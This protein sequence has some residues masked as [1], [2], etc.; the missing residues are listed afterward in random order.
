MTRALGILG[1]FSALSALSAVKPPTPKTEWRSYGGDPGGMRYSPLK[2]INRGNVAKL[3]RAW[4]Y[5]HGELVTKPGERL[6]AFQSTPIVVDGIL[7]FSTPS[8]RIIAL[9][10]DSGRE[11]WTFDP[12]AGT[13]KRTYSAHRGVAY[14]SSA[15]RRDRRILFG[16]FDA[17]LI[18]LDAITGKPCI[19]FGQN[20]V[21]NLKE[22]MTDH[23][24]KSDY[25]TSSPPAIY[26]DIA[27]IGS[28]V[29]EGPGL[30][31]SGDVRA[32]DVRTGAE[33]WRFHTIP[34]P[35]EPGHETWEGDSWKDR[36]GV[37]V[38]T[39]MTVDE[40]RGLVFLPTGSAA[41]DFY[42][43]DRKGQNLYANCLVALDA[44]T[45]KKRWHY[46]L[47]HHDIWDYDLP[48]PP[49]LITIR[50][51]GR[52]IP[53][54]AQVTKM[55]FVFVFNRI[56]GEPLFPIEERPVPQSTVPGETTWPT[57]PFPLKPPPLSRQH[58]VTRDDLNDVTPE[59]RSAALKLF[60]ELAVSGGIYTPLGPELTLFWPGTL[61]GCTWSGASYDPKRQYLFTNVNETGA[62][63]RMVA[64]PAGSG[65]AYRRTSSAGDYA[66]FWDGKYPAVKPPWGKLVA[67]DLSKGTIAWEK[68]LG[69][70]PE[71]MSRGIPPTGTPNLG[72]SIST[73]GDLVFIGGSNDSLF[74]A[75]D[76]SNGKELWTGRLE[77]SGHATPMTYLGKNSGRQFVVIA[78]GGGWTFSTTMSDVLA[79]YALP[80]K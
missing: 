38:W 10:A 43:G 7:Y 6:P 28:R 70:V 14:W 30:G 18:A 32:F 9:D 35:S 12:Q 15:D 50:R 29:P 45:G 75:F 51:H 24:P 72:G 26:K 66:R 58:P 4:T 48:A 41:Y 27:I 8:N 25:G 44:P 13:S 22:G 31:P 64:A 76:S 55:G 2:Q 65:I 77:A 73:A 23:F 69:I 74:R 42:G 63:G 33:V 1:A 68:P 61:G 79:A 19:G 36:T 60:E 37:N 49:N 80:K 3:E 39:M 71:L 46:Q 62:I 56:T 5:H 53:A 54:V 21:V 47:V 57:Q 34:R 11:L 17:R 52:S 40:E 16:T 20:G 59:S 67:V 78:A